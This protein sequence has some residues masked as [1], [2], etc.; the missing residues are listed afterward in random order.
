MRERIKNF[1]CI[2]IFLFFLWLALTFPLK[3]EEIIS[4]CFISL[5]LALFLNKLYFNLGASFFKFQRNLSSL[6][7]NSGKHLLWIDVKTKSGWIILMR[8]LFMPGNVEMQW[9][10]F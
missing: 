4:G 9:R 7:L 5:V 10:F 6:L 1:F 8:I 3:K 2:F